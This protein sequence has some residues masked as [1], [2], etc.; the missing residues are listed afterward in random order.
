MNAKAIFLLSLALTFIGFSPLTGQQP[1]DS[2]YRNL[3]SAHLIV[4]L[5][6]HEKK[7]EAMTATLNDPALS[8]A[9]RM[10]L[11]AQLETVK[12]EKDVK[13]RAIIKA[14]QEYFDAL[15]VA[16]V[17]DTTHQPRRASFLNEQLEKTVTPELSDNLLQLRFGR[18]VS[19]AGSRAESMVLTDSRLQDLGAPF[20]KPVL[21]TGFG[22]GF[23]KLLA[24]ETAFEKLLA[25]RV[26][27]LDQ[28]L[29]AL[30]Y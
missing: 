4:R 25:K 11:Q 18:P 10:R 2:L 30:I 28:K 17:Y 13:N 23:N 7:I 26:K 9:A 14:F 21:M 12:V 20:P 24:P 22:Y 3:G 15:P 16:F 5:P 27:K 29:E 6:S 19:Y 8:D 1:E